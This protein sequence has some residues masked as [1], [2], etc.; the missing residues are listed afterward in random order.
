MKKQLQ[1]LLNSLEKTSSAYWN[2]PRKTGQFLNLLIRTNNYKNIL[3]IGTSNGYSGIWMAEA[4]T[5]GTHSAHNKSRRNKGH[6][7]TI[8]SHK[9]ERFYLAE[10]NFK[11]SGLGKYITQILGHAPEAIPKT[12]RK[13][14]FVFLD[15]TKYEYIDYF[16]AVASRIKKGGILV[17]DNIN[18]HR[19][20]LVSFIKI[21]Q[22]NKNFTTFLF[23]LG[24]GLLVTVKK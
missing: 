15:A 19:E 12:P 11:K 5:K 18:T 8:E 16:K 24:S 13:F 22:K 17:A 21:V 4:L 7:Y 1:S 14:D 6:L 2:I 10:E 23:D 3:E 9:Q 20:E